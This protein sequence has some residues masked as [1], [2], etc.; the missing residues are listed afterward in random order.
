MSLS[1]IPQNS[2][3]DRT[4]P[5]SEGPASLAR[6]K[7]ARETALGCRENAAA[8]MLRAGGMDTVNGRQVFETSAASWTKRAE[9]LQRIETGIEARQNAAAPAS[10]DEDAPEL[11]SEEIAEDAAYQQL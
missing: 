6:G 1:N 9:M 7:D 10:T 2:I 8:D 11:T 4:D 5:D 3:S